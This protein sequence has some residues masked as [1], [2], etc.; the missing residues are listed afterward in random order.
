MHIKDKD[1]VTTLSAAPDGVPLVAAVFA[2]I[3]TAASFTH[4]LGPLGNYLI[5]RP[6]ASSKA[7]SDGERADIPLDAAMVLGLSKDALHVWS[8]DPMLGQVND[9]LGSVEIARVTGM[10]AEV[11]KGSW[12][13]L[14]ITL[15]SAESVEVQA[16]GDVS[17]L[18][19]AFRGLGGAQV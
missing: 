5:A 14:T 15:D 18:V 11:Q 7:G 3:T 17:G 13:P 16:R 6:A 1:L 19:A 12:W 8:A 4:W 2:R 9:H 10:A